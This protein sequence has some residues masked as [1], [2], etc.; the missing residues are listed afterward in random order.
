MIFYIHIGI[1]ILTRALQ[2]MFSQ[3]VPDS[4]N[5]TRR[6]VLFWI[7]TLNFNKIRKDDIMKAQCCVFVVVMY[8]DGWW[9]MYPGKNGSCFI[10]WLCSAGIMIQQ[11]RRKCGRF[12]ISGFVHTNASVWNPN[13]GVQWH[14]H[15]N[16]Q[17]AQHCSL[18]ICRV[19]QSGSK[20]IYQV[21]VRILYG[22]E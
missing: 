10:E 18:Q 16:L 8:K 9:G 4:C 17:L 20:Y 15:W 22:E 11:K 12:K 5:M 3:S 19:S 7:S 1:F 14:C 21:F 6:K 2:R 13:M